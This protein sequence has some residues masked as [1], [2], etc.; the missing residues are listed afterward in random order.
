MSA[1]WGVDPERVDGLNCDGTQMEQGSFIGL[2][3]REVALFQSLLTGLQGQGVEIGCMDGFSSSVILSYSNLQLTSI[4]PLI[5]D[6]MDASVVGNKDR[7]LR[8]LAP[9]KS[10]WT[11]IQGYSH[12]VIFSW[13]TILE[14]L[15]IDGDHNYEAC[16]RDLSQWRSWLRPGGILAMHDS[17]MSRPGGAPF[18]PGPSRVAAEQIYGQPDKWEILGEAFSLTVA[19]KKK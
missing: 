11:F 1:S 8:N 16:A 7:L 19:R 3:P 2:G 10:R 13:D 6:S 12:E 4:D 18:H 14:F 5:G 9:F 15:F 17:R